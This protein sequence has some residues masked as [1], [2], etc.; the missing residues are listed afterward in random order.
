MSNIVL[1]ILLFDLLA[2]SD[3]S[4]ITAYSFQFSGQFY[5]IFV[6]YFVTLQTVET[7]CVF[8]NYSE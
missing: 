8:L 7:F 3:I 5:I 1:W 2:L 4:S 6:T